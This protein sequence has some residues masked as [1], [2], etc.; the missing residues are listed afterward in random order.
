MSHLGPEISGLLDGRLAPDEAERVLAHLAVCDD[1]AAEVAAARA[2]RAALAGAGDVTPD[3]RLTARLLALGS[4]T[5]P[6]P[7]RRTPPLGA[8]SLPMPGSG[9]PH[10]T[11][12]GDLAPR[13]RPL[14]PLLAGVAGAG[15]L[16]TCFSLGNE[17]QVTVDARPAQALTALQIASVATGSPIDLDAWFAAHPWAVPVTVPAGHQVAAVRTDAD[18]LEIDLIGPDG[19]VVV[20]Q[21]RGRLGEVGTAIEVGGHE[22][23]QLA[24]SPPCV[25]WQA[26]DA[27]VAVVA[28][29]SQQAVE[30]VVA[31]YPVEAYDDGASARL[32]RGWHVLLTAWSSS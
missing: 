17:P 26:G 7:P 8:G 4:V 16:V 9:L 10:G 28:S 6:G 27:V 23:R 20:R 25:A 15:L 22:V 5:P 29:G 12:R 11:V 3:P 1:C 24:S 21:T 19:L 18:E 14:V 32:G 2:T 31:A 30:P 13:R